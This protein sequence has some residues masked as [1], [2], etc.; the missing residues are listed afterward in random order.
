[1][2]LNLII[3][4]ITV[5]VLN[6]PFGYWRANVKK[7]GL[8]WALS[9]HIPVPFIILL[10]IYSNIG[11]AWYTY[12]FLVSAFFFGQRL[13][14]WIHKNRLLHHKLTTSCLVMDVARRPK[15]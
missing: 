10:R 5:F 12:I 13:G 6:I 11:F 9:V 8:Q 14:A 4:T 1:M 7:F 3:V 2:I 15:N